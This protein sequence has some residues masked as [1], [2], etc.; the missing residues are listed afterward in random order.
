LASSYGDV[1]DLSSRRGNRL[2]LASDLSAADAHIVGDLRSLGRQPCCRRVNQTATA[3][4]EQLLEDQRRVLGP[5]HPHT[6]TTRNN[7]A[8]ARGMAGDPTCAAAALEELLH[9]QL[10]ILGPNHPHTLA[11]RHNIARW[12]AEAGNP[13]AAAEPSKPSATANESS[14]PTTPDT[15]STHN[16]L[17]HRRSP[18]RPTT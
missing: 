2:G 13:T 18:D 14:D 16:E 9:D 1:Q 3:A 15:L 11:T 12:Q 5:N 6:L 7:I 8:R 10:R 17:E 4:L